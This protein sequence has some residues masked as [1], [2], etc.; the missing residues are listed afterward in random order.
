M[1]AWYRAQTPNKQ[2]QRTVTRRRGDG[3][4]APFHCALVPRVT[5]QRAAAELR[6]YTAWLGRRGDNRQRAA[7]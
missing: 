6:R 2:L 7:R 3:T 5:R 4:S 1:K